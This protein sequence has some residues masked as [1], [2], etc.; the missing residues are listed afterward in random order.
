[1]SDHEIR[2]KAIR[3]LTRNSGEC[4]SLVVFQFSVVALLVLCES[5]L[6]L[7]LKSVGYNWLYSV[8]DFFT[9]RH[10]TILFW[11]SK[12]V[13]EFAV[14]APSFGLARRLFLDIAINGDLIE[15]RQYITAHS[16]KYYT[17]LFY[18]SLVQFFVKLTVMTPGLISM[19]GVY[20]WAREITLNHLT[21]FA[22]L[23]LT[24]SLSFTAVWAF[25]SLR[26]CVSLALTPYIMAL[27]PR[28]SVFD[29]CD[30]SIKVM[31]GKHGRYLSFLLHFLKF[32]PAMVLVYPFFA[33]Y[34]YFKVCYA[35]FMY[36]MLG[37]RNHDKLPGMIKRWKKYL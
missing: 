13:I 19:Y 15:T 33:I 3:R 35:L 18:S 31:E 23:A 34:P 25:L 22:L 14:C 20:H 29:A 16:V 4:V 21:S 8:R 1:M 10:S 27:N 7:S 5:T 37:E 32:L 9:G 11:L 26:Y 12:T 6:Y 30:L 24:G 17:N 2:Q 36:E 28:S